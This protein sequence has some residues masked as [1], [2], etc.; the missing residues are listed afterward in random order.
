MFIMVILPKERPGNQRVIL[1]LQPLHQKIIILFSGISK[2]IYLLPDNLQ[3][4]Y[5]VL[6]Q[7]TWLK[8]Y[9]IWDKR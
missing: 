7:K 8:W 3:L 1:N 9:E 4:Q 5:V 2:K 6:N